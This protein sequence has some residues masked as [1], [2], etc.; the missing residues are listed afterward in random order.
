[1]NK[2]GTLLFALL[3]MFSGTSGAA[4][5]PEWTAF[6][7]RFISPDGR[8]IDYINNQISTSEGQAY[9]M[10]IAV[11]T[12]DRKSFDLVWNWAKHNLQVRNIDKLMAW[13]WGERA[14]GKWTIIDLNNATD[15]DILAA[16]ALLD[17]SRKWNNDNYR[18]EALVLMESLREHVIM[19]KWQRM[20]TLPGYFG[21]IRDES[22]LINPSYL[23]VSAY[24]KF[25]PYSEQNF[26]NKLYGD[27]LFILANSTFGKF[28]LPADWTTWQ[29]EGAK[30]HR[31]KS[32]L[33]GYEAVRVLLYLSWDHNIK[34]L[35]GFG[36][37]L[38]VVKGIGYIPISVNL[39]DDS[40]SMN[41]ASGGFY[42]VFARAAGDLGREELSRD[43]WKK[44][45]EKIRYEKDDYY[46]NILYLLSK[47]NMSE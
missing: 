2:A 25:A 27:S 33:F 18:K 35:K 5:Q 9:A 21:F 3:I 26:W 40:I 44:A 34:L 31:E 17:A 8:V 47:I 37:Y 30:V 13:K 24:K 41:D 15:G 42:A 23:V 22:L 10:L 20:F 7:D 4:E 12:G 16:L 1:M 39:T 45:E 29:R 11:N 6:K 32:D 38:D 14:P 36:E 46:S 28:G 43:L 19:E